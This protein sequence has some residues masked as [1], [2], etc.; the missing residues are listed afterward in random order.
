MRKKYISERASYK[1]RK[2]SERLR[3]F[4][5]SLR[6][7]NSHPEIPR[8]LHLRKNEMKKKK[9]RRD[10]GARLAVAKVASRIVQ[11]MSCT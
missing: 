4:H 1:E 11:M 3:S 8:A 9:T 2:N 10:N 7:E 5:L 6:K